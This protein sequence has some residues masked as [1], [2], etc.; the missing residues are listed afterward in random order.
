MADITLVDVPSQRVIGMQRRGPYSQIAVLLGELVSY[1]M[2]NGVQ[3]AGAPVA[4]MHEAGKEEVERADREGN[5]LIDVAFP[6]VGSC[7]GTGEIRCYELPGG[8]MAKTV[9][10]G[11]Y[12]AC[13]PTYVALW[14]WIAREGKRIT[15][16]TREIYLNDPREVPPEEI[17]TEIHAPVA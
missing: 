1:A 7:E 5:A 3:L 8:T 15:G 2:S 11:P 4:L 12:E 9:H 17:L 16:P 14:Q 10:K 6:I 13:E